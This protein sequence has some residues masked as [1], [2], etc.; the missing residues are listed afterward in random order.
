[1]LLHDCP[2]PTLSSSQHTPLM[3]TRINRPTAAQQGTRRG[4]RAA[5]QAGRAIACRAMDPPLSRCVKHA[6]QEH[7]RRL[8]PGAHSLAAGCNSSNEK[9]GRLHAASIR[10]GPRQQQQQ[11]QQQQHSTQQPPRPAKCSTQQLLCGIRKEQ[12]PCTACWAGDAGA[13]HARTDTPAKLRPFAMYVH[14]IIVVSDDTRCETLP[15]VLTA[16]QQLQCSPREEG[17]PATRASIARR[18]ASKSH[19]QP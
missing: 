13:P 14:T 5:R 3:G 1:M 17:W 10:A 19:A 11:Q 8:Q 12:S 7:T 9:Q 6:G 2:P 16:L 18:M 15:H 4:N